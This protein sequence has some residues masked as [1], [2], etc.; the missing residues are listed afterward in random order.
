MGKPRIFLS[1][2]KED[3]EKV[4]R[5]YRKLS[6]AGFKPWMD[7]HGILP[8][9]DW[10][11]SILKAM[12][13]S[14]F[15]VI[16]LSSNSV[17][18]RGYFQ[19][20]MRQAID[21]LREKLDSDNYL[22]IA[23]LDECEVPEILK[24]LR[25]QWED[26]FKKGGFARLVKAIQE[27]MKRRNTQSRRSIKSNPPTK[28]SRG[29]SAMQNKSRGRPVKRPPAGNASN[30]GVNG[31]EIA[32]PNIWIKEHRIHV[33]IT[34]NKRVVRQTYNLSAYKNDV[35]LY[36]F[37]LRPM[38][39]GKIVLPR[40]SKDYQKSTGI[41]LDDQ[42]IFFGRNNHWEYYAV[43]FSNTLRKEMSKRIEFSFEALDVNRD[44][45][46][47]HALS[48]T[49]FAGCDKL[50]M[51]VKFFD[52]LI[53]DKVEVIRGDNSYNDLPSEKGIYV[54]HEAIDPHTSEYSFEIVPKPNENY[55]VRWQLPT[56]AT[57]DDISTGTKPAAD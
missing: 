4:K 41:Q 30:M 23:R 16:C 11:L 54:R 20:E 34:P 35:D 44:M 50:V 9:E 8:G 3:R 15:V 1:Y 18:K 27:D 26:L 31:R 38:G 51:S 22:I 14:N 55:T 6:D 7:K 39:T 57:A 37:K 2:V 47:Y 5:L 46:P 52:P 45:P 49:Q 10:T 48:Y 43:V 12:K 24:N 33:E 19:Y 40:K 36:R 42:T 21:F 32:N 17:T 56:T 53:P 29:R 25:R 28:K 13:N